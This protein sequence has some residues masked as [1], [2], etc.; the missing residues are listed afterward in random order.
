MWTIE[1]YFFT[2]SE[3]EKSKTKVPADL[4]FG[5]SFRGLQA[6][7]F[8]P[9]PHGAERESARSLLSLRLRTLILTYQDPTLMTSLNL[10]YVLTYLQMQPHWGAGF[11][12]WTWG[13]ISVQ[14]TITQQF[15]HTHGG[16][17]ATIVKYRKIIRKW[18]LFSIHYL[19][20]NIVYLIVYL[21]HLTWA[22]LNWL[23]G[24]LRSSWHVLTGHSEQIPTSPSTPLAKQVSS[25]A[26]SRIH[27][28]V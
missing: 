12:V 14:R 20:F 28:L 3:S 18:W 6:A 21:H 2:F 24:C 26:G 22:I 7:P 4:V 1:T 15:Y 23:S 9:W 19:C 11:N 17:Q 27:I 16:S 10:N 13:H 25:R 8:S 5:E